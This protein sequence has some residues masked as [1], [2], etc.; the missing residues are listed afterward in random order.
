MKNFY[1]SLFTKIDDV[2]KKV[3]EAFE[4]FQEKL[5]K[6]IDSEMSTELANLPINFWRLS[7]DK[8]KEYLT[9]K[10]L[11]LRCDL[12]KGTYGENTENV[13]FL[14]LL[15][16]RIDDMLLPIYTLGLGECY[17]NEPMYIKKENYIPNHSVIWTAT[18]R[19]SLW[20]LFNAKNEVLEKIPVF[21]KYADEVKEK[22]H[23][24]KKYV[25]KLNAEMESMK[26]DMVLDKFE[27]YVTIAIQDF[28]KSKKSATVKRELFEPT[29][30]EQYI[31]STIIEG[32]PFHL[33]AAPGENT[34]IV[35]TIGELR[36]FY[37]G[38]LQMPEEDLSRTR[39]QSNKGKK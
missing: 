32:T 14:K 15:I 31:L 33:M 6:Q 35:Y 12:L 28:L 16:K 4:R 17:I 9:S 37:Y 30:E 34:K 26:F 23:G 5:D 18:I 19:I 7:D 10:T 27:R 24:N 11:Y 38:M 8:K 2:D 3:S 21:R 39:K 1:Q 36:D 13:E 22:Y 25:E 29:S 20:S